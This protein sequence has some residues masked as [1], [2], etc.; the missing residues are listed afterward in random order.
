MASGYLFR[1]ET[2]DRLPLLHF[3]PLLFDR[4]EQPKAL[5][6]D[7]FPPHTDIP[8]EYGVSHSFRGG[9]TSEV[10]NAGLPSDVISECLLA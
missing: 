2:I 8:A 5:H 10:V 7:L 1:T 4:L 9:D 6:P 3:E